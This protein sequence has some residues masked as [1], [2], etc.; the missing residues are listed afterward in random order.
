MKPCIP[1]AITNAGGYQFVQ[2]GAKIALEAISTPEGLPGVL[3]NKGTWPISTGEQG[4]KAK[5]LREQGN[6]KNVLGNKALLKGG[7]KIGEKK[8]SQ[9]LILGHFLC[10]HVA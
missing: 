1:K 2:K 6:K 4:N 10:T 3:G 5:Y 8:T 9:E 7:Q